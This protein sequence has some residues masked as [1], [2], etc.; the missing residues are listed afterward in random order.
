MVGLQYADVFHSIIAAGNYKSRIMI[1]SID[2]VQN[3]IN[4][5]SRTEVEEYATLMK[6]FVSDTNS[7]GRVAQDGIK[8]NN[9]FNKDSEYTIGNAPICNIEISFINDDGYFATYD[10]GQTAIIYWDVYDPTN[11]YWIG[12][13]LGVYWWERPTKTSEIIVTAKAYDGMWRL[14]QYEYNFP[15]FDNGLN[16]AAIYTDIVSNIP[17]I[18][19]YPNPQNWA[20]MTLTT[21]YEAPFDTTNMTSRQVLAKLAEIAGSNAYISRDGYVMLKPFTDAWWVEY[22]QAPKKYYTLNSDSMPTP[23]LG[24]SIG[25]YTVPLIDK[26]IAQV[27]QSGEVF[28]S[29]NGSNVMYSVNNGF[30]NIPGASARYTVD[31]MYGVVSGQHSSSDMVAYVPISLRA[32]AD[33][34][35]EGGDII[36]VIRNGVTYLMPVFQQILRWTG[37]DWIVEMQNSGYAVRTIPSEAERESYVTEKRLSSLESGGGGGGGGADPATVPASASIDANGLI[38]FKNSSSSTL[39]TLQLPVYN[40]GGS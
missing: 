12:C 30:L 15:S 8:I 32:Y 22:P 14:D 20:N 4:V 3:P 10:W 38:S 28:T 2:L 21:Y 5:D 37:G 16:L 17:G 1:Y 27:G 24:L 34:S 29:G 33:P 39:F 40:G 9:Y 13:P 36:R 26:F 19:P 7:N 11:N 35:V 6:Y 18:I 23:I 31:G 25:E